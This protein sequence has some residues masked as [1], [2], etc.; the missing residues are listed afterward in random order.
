MIQN[1]KSINNFD[2]NFYLTNY[3]VVSEYMAEINSLSLKEKLYNHYINYGAKLGCYANEYDAAN[4]SPDYKIISDLT[5]TTDNCSILLETPKAQWQYPANTEKHYFNNHNNSLLKSTDNW[6][7]GFPWASLINSNM[8]FD[9]NV[10]QELKTFLSKLNGRKHTV[11]QHIWWKRLAYL[12]EAIGLTD[13]HLSHYEKNIYNTNNLTFH[14]WPITSANL[15]NSGRSTGLNFKYYDNK[16]YLAS[17]I[18]S[19]EN[20][21]YR[22]DSRL[23][24]QQVFSNIDKIYFK[25]YDSWFYHDVV[26]RNQ[27]NKEILDTKIIDDFDQKTIQY[28]EV[29][30]DSVFSLCPEGSGP[31]TIRLWESM[32]V[33]T[34][35]VIYSDDWIPPTQYQAALEKC[36]VFISRTEIDKTIKILSS[37]DKSVIQNMQID[38]INTYKDIKNMTCF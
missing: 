26:N 4:L 14:S 36:C 8:S 31:N 7:I 35:P 17:F 25:L 5:I 19:Y 15:E 11:C 13:V 30:S 2:E 27:I 38:C 16:K 34:I 32:S 29:L 12:W 20:Y 22:N 9:I 1:N 3:P 21:N 24:L 10:I 18:G 23:K 33:G 6:Y 37:Y 28:N